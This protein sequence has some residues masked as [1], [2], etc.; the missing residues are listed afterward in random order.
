[1]R[2]RNML[3]WLRTVFCAETLLLL[4][5]LRLLVLV[6]LCTGPSSWLSRPLSLLLPLLLTTAWACPAWPAAGA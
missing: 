3:L 4:L 5:L 2:S 6:H 1:M